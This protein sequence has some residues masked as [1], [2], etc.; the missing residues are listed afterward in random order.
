MKQVKRLVYMIV[1]NIIVSAIT[2]VIILNIWER[3]HP[4]LP[5]AGTPAVIVVT[6][7]QSVV[8]PLVSNLPQPS[9]GKPTDT[10]VIINSTPAA[11][12]AF[13]IEMVVY[14]V[15]E[16][17]T[18]G[19]LAVEFNASVADIMTVNGIT[20][21]NSLYIGQL[22]RI[23]TSPL[24]T[25]THTPLPT[26]TAT[27]TARPSAT[28]TPGPTATSTP[29]QPSQE[30]QVYIETVIGAGVLANEHVVLQRTGNGEL[31][32]AGWRLN[33]GAGNSYSFPQ[34]TL[35]KGGTVDLYTR[36]GEDNVSDLY[37]GL[38]ISIWN[39]GKTVY[40]YDAQGE[41]RSS[42]KVP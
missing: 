1:L 22:I 23:P 27:A 14:Q 42:Y 40:L 34:L 4:P 19:A 38:N 31:S 7:T 36:S 26:E 16:G 35:Y 18:L 17:D 37:W 3:N 10:G 11:S 15:K 25:I 2:V 30:P 39:A 8:I 28:T 12:Q 21:P 9:E 33:D 5:A 20:D 13:D 24:P 41:L 32:M 29:T 6:P